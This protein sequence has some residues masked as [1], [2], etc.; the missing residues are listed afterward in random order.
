[1]T[2]RDPDLPA[3]HAV[4]V[5]VCFYLGEKITARVVLPH[6][7]NNAELKRVLLVIWNLYRNKITASISAGFLTLCAAQV[8]R[9]EC[10]PFYRNPLKSKT[11]KEKLQLQ[12]PA[13]V[14]EH[15]SLKHIDIWILLSL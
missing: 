7:K 4:I 11:G 9:A 3:L 14:H 15:F 12:T 5:L 8:R 2:V 6:L 13:C 1:M 10:K